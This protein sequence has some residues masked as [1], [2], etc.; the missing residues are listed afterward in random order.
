MPTYVYQ[1]K[2]GEKGCS[3]CTDGFEVVQSMS[4][5]PLGNCPRCSGAVERVITPPNIVKSNK[6]MLSDRNLK[7]HG[8]Q[9]FVK[10]E[11]GVYRKTT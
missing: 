1:K 4:D 5:A 11:K 7:G 9:R 8:F 2:A 10:E 6:S 3:A